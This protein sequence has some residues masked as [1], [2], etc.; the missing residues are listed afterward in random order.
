MFF[1]QKLVNNNLVAEIWERF[2]VT[3]QLGL[4]LRVGLILKSS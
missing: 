1:I 2:V 4:I 3:S